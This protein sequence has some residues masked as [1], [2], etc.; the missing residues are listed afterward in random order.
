MKRFTLFFIIPLM[1]FGFFFAGAVQAG[2]EHNVSGWAWSNMDDSLTPADER[3]IGWIS[4]NCTDREAATGKTCLDAND[5]TFNPEVNLADYG[6]KIDPSTG[7]FSG[8]A[9]AGG[10]E[11][12]DGTQKPTIGWINFEPAGPYPASPNSSAKE[13]LANGEVSGWAR[14]LAYGGGWDGWIKLRKG[15]S[16]SGPDY[17]VSINTANGEFSG[18]AWSDMVIGWIHFNG[19]NYGVRTSPT[20]SENQPP[21][22][23]ATI[24]KDGSNYVDS[25]T[26]T[27]G[28][29]TPI[30]LSAAGSSDP[31]GW[32]N[33]TN[34]VSSGGKCEW[35]SDLN[36][37]SPTFES[38]IN[39][40]ASPSNCNIS[41]GNLTFNDAPG[42]YTYQ[43]LRITDKPGAVSNVDTVSVIVE[44]EGN[45]PPLQP[46]SPPEYPDGESWDHCSIQGLSIPTFHWTYSDPENDAQ[47][48]YQIKIYGETTLNETVN[49]SA[50]PCESYTP[51]TNWVRDNL[52]WS[53]TY[54]WRV[55]VKDNQWSGWSYDNSFAMP[56]HAYPNPDFSHS[57]TGAVVNFTDS[58]ICYD[59]NNVSYP[60]KNNSLNNY[61]WNFGDGSSNSTRGDTSH[62]YS[63]QGPYTV[64]LSVTDDV[65]T[66]TTQG[67]S[68]VG[69][70]I[71]PPNWR[72]IPPF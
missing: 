16:D 70:T 13:N 37:G 4:F 24:S 10:G 41:L 43:V 27:Q 54:S 30:Y 53:E 48:A 66:C 47:S 61:L 8:Y 58:S 69:A 38:T 50:P 55:R 46:T 45:Q 39:N 28:V 67:D 11:D 17:G 65:G 2:T 63:G 12:A 23:V 25:I 49:C 14:A 57:I 15:P 62:V 36:Q 56:S 20:P 21:V 32:T 18:Y 64:T 9:W 19:A 42:T 6:V 33:P 71:P 35:N 31:D 44:A 51:T 5:P 68:P 26:V 34:G 3:S 29:A 22:A 1:V 52:N 40:P 72:E 60:C 59:A 7:V